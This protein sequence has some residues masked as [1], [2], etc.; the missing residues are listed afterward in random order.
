MATWLRVC[1]GT[2]LLCSLSCS[3]DG[4]AENA[5]P[6]QPGSDASTGDDQ[7]IAAFTTSTCARQVECQNPSAG[8]CRAYM[9]QQ[10]RQALAK[11]TWTQAQLQQCTADRRRLVMCIAAAD[12]AAILAVSECPAEKDAYAG[13]CEPLLT[14]LNG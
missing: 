14:A 11:V 7:L 1:A 8:N 12:C 13:S 10:V 2:L 9:E 5:A 3:G 6:Q 4:G